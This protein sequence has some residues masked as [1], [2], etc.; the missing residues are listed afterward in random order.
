M[1]V[2]ASA[3]LNEHPV[4]LAIGQGVM[5]LGMLAALLW[6]ARRPTTRL[7]RKERHDKKL[8][9]QADSERYPRALRTETELT[10]DATLIH[11]LRTRQETLHT[12]GT[13]VVVEDHKVVLAVTQS[14]LNQVGIKTR[15][16]RSIQEALPFTEQDDVLVADW[17]L[18]DGTAPELVSAFHEVNRDGP[19]ILTSAMDTPPSVLPAGAVWLTKPYEPDF[20]IALVR[21]MLTRK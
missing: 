20:F 13:V 21:K 9:K 19:V 3:V 15:G 8:K 5:G 11:A 4:A 14:L 7:G 2:V 10:R 16:A 6:A 17:N 12:P 1:S 18:P